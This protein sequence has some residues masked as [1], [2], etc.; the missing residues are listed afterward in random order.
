[1]GMQD[2]D[3]RAEKG[4]MIAE[5]FGQVVRLEEQAYKVR[6]QS[7]DRYYEVI[8][9]EKGWECQCPDFVFRG[10]TCKHIWAVQFS[11]ELRKA[12]EQSVVI[13]PLNIESCPSC[14]S[15]NVVKH[16]L[17]HNGYGNLQRF[18]CKQC[19]KRFVVN[20]GFEKM[21]ATPQM[22]TSAMQLYFTGE[23]FRNVQKFLLL[24]G[25]KVS[26]VAIYKWVAKYVSLMQEY[27]EKIQPKV[28]NA[29]RTDELYVK[30]KGNNKYLFAMMDDDTRFWIAQQVAAHKGTSDVRPMFREAV[31][32]AGKKPKLLISDGAQNFHE[33]YLKEYRTR[34]IDSPQHERDIRLDGTVHNNKMERMNGELRDRERVMRSIKTE[35][36]PIFK[37]LQ[38]YHNYFRPHMALEGATPAE[39]AGIKIE[40]DNKWIT[41][42]HNATR[43]RRG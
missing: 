8:G 20:L 3:T 33:A 32:I 25:V 28:G 35:D 38:L 29:W 9:T 1:M 6:S 17:R 18:S 7:L 31:E 4:K 40:G 39:R 13:Q 30:I 21:H 22:I 24:Q 2:L 42:I 36:S 10:L 34:Y 11:F 5:T 12:V 26:H 23:S 37:G 16:G 43:N 14:A 27:V 15:H 41:L 19:G